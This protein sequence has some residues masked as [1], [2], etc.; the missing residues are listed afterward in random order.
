VSGLNPILA[1]KLNDA[2]MA[3]SSPDF[4]RRDARLPA[5]PSKVHAVVGM[6]RA[7]KTTFLKQLQRDLR[8][9][10]P[11]ERVVYLSF[12]DDRLD[13]LG[14]D[15][16]NRLLEEFFRRYPDLR[17]TETVHWLLDEIQLVDGWERF[18]RRVKDS[19]QMEFI[20]SGSSAKLLS[21]EVHTSLRGRGME[22][23][24]GPFSFGEYLRHH[25]VLPKSRPDRLTSRERSRVEGCFRD[26]LLAGGFPEAQGLDL[27]LRVELLQGYVDTVLFRDVLERHGFSQV[28]GL[29][30]LTRHCLRSPARPLS[31]HRIY[32]DFR[33]QGRSVGKDVLYSMM[34][35]LEDAFLIRGVSLATDSER[36]RNSNPRRYYP[37]DTGLIGAYDRTGKTNVGHALETVVLHELDRRRMEV[38]Y[39]LTPGGFEV[40]FLARDAAG[41][42]TL[43][44]VC[45]DLAEANTLSRE[46]R[47][48]RDAAEIHPLADQLMIV[49]QADQLPAETPDDIRILP[50]WQWLLSSAD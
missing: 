26:Y 25:D 9:S 29:R 11:P 14:S 21:R 8:Q 32:R 16:L 6:R 10:L 7:G 22:T 40:D 13:D 50:A 38:G 45:A 12:D 23:R 31:V 44:Q 2:V 28:A 47:A 35:G 43:V 20:V 36:R 18:V 30:W 33:A 19:E 1:A 42:E 34:A 5:V 24:I 37:A 27:P 17:S 3:E 41:K 4:T 15:Q 49:L 39:V 46:L 48:L